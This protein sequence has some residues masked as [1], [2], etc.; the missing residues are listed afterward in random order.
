MEKSVIASTEFAEQ[1]AGRVLEKMGERGCPYRTDKEWAIHDKAHEGLDKLLEWTNPVGKTLK[2]TLIRLGVYLLIATIAT[3]I[4]IL[5]PINL[6]SVIRSA[7]GR[8]Q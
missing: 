5:T 2:N 8:G 7:V 6:A 3:A 1:I 4:L